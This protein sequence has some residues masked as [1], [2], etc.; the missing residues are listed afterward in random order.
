M[1]KWHDEPI[2]FHVELERV[3]TKK[4]PTLI[5]T[6]ASLDKRI[7]ELLQTA[8]PGQVFW[9]DEYDLLEIKLPHKFKD[10]STIEAEVSGKGSGY[11]HPATWH[12]CSE[13][14]DERELIAV[15][16]TCY[17]EEGIPIDDDYEIDWQD[18]KGDTFETQL[19]EQD[20]DNL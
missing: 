2:T 16:L 18:I 19:H 5:G 11:Y 20:Y 4:L 9:L 10:A 3:T 1:S 8:A 12:S 15:I 13:E 17:N 7:A 6:C 14:E